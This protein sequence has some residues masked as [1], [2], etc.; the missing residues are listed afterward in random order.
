MKTKLKNRRQTGRMPRGQTPKVIDSIL[1]TTDF[2]P[3]S[4]KGVKYASMLAQKFH[5]K[6]T[7]LHVIEPPP[8]FSGFEK[9]VIARDDAALEFAARAKL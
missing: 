8:R 6:L 2:S 5:S 4:M 1:T 9:V 7:L 3:E